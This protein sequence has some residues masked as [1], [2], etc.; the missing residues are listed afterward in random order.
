VDRETKVLYVIAALGLLI[1]TNDA[2]L[3]NGPI[4]AG[5]WGGALVA[6]SIPFWPL[7]RPVGWRLPLVVLVGTVA[8]TVFDYGFRAFRHAM[9]M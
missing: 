7:H 5:L 9:G 4:A 6:F 2:A 1:V 3:R 8:A